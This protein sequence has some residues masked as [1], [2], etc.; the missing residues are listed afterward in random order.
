M[1]DRRPE[2]REMS[3]SKRVKLERNMDPTA[4][5]Y[6]AHHYNSNGDGYAPAQRN[7]SLLAHFQRHNTT[8]EQAHLAEDGPN[9]P[10]NGAPLSSTYFSILKTRRHLPVH[11]QR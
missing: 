6:L 11:K 10:F 2:D 9:N 1:A 7:S 4:N 8:A 3:A 5:P